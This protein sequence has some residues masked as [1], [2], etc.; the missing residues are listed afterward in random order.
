M[1][2]PRAQPIFGGSSPSG[3]GKALA[4]GTGGGPG[5]ELPI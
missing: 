4:D 5:A 2:V 3:S 1:E